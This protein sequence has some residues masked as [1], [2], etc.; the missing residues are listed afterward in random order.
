MRQFN[1]YCFNYIEKV[2]KLIILYI[3]FTLNYIKYIQ[4]TQENIK[5]A[6]K[7]LI[8]FRLLS[9]AGTGYTYLGSKNSK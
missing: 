3:F 4:Y 5:M 7:G 2:R 9:S 6:K 1:F 8:L